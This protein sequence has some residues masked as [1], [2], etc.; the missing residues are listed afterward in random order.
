MKGGFKCSCEDGYLLEDDHKYC[1][2]TG[3]LTLTSISS[4]Q[5][6]YNRGFNFSTH[7]PCKI[8]A[9]LVS[10]FIVT[11]SFFIICYVYC[12]LTSGFKK[13]IYTIYI[14]TGYINAWSDRFL[15]A[16]LNVLLVES[17]ELNPFRSSRGGFP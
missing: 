7:F 13:L 6:A 16:I 5:A 17:R 15:N 8:K 4:T 9:Y 2:A 1:K 14:Y 3:E 11:C 10:W 12:L